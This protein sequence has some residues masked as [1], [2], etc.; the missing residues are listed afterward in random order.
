MSTLLNFILGFLTKL[1]LYQQN[2][3]HLDHFNYKP[4]PLLAG[5]YTIRAHPDSQHFASGYRHRNHPDQPVFCK[6]K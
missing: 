3:S 4:Y 5:L 1:T 6:A 2:D